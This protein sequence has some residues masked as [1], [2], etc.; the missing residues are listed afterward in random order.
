MIH[1]YHCSMLL[2]FLFCCFLLYLRIL[3]LLYSKGSEWARERE[4]TTTITWTKLKDNYNLRSLKCTIDSCNFFFFHSFSCIIIFQCPSMPI[5]KWLQT[6]YFISLHIKSPK[7]LGFILVD[8]HK[9]QQWNKR[10]DIEIN[11]KMRS[12]S[13]EKINSE[14]KKK[15]KQQQQIYQP[16]IETFANYMKFKRALSYRWLF[17]LC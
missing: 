16:M 7:Y 8:L 17:E 12:L 14:I 1:N 6:F 13:N 11:K 10:N 5:L 2:L 4:T 9:F 3:L 15:K